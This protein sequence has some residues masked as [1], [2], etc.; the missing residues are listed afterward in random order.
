MIL[1]FVIPIGILCLIVA[2]LCL[3]GNHRKQALTFS[4][5]GL[6]SLGVAVLL[7]YWTQILIQQLGQGS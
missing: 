1:F 2:W 6:S 5:I 4:L 3:R 7:I